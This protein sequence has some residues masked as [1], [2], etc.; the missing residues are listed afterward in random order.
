MKGKDFLS[1][2]SALI[3]VAGITL[4]TIFT[5]PLSASTIHFGV[6]CEEDF[7]NN[8]APEI[9]VYSACDDYIGVIQ[10]YYPAYNV[11]FYFNL[12]GA[13]PAF[14]YGQGAETCNSCGGVDSVDFFTMMTHGGVNG[15]VAG[16][17]MWDQNIFAYTNSMRLGDSGKQVK[18]LATFSCDTFKNDDGYFW[19]RW[20]KAFSGGLKVGVGA[21]DLL[22]TDDDDS[23][24]QDFA[25][26]IVG[27]VPIGYSWLYAVY[28]DNNDNHPTVA[29]TGAN[30]NDCWSRQGVKLS[31]LM[32][33]KVLRDGQIGYYCWTNWN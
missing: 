11:D 21:H 26:G 4:L 22:Y 10:S 14:V 16:Y 31:G 2:R 29:N 23:A 20:Q 1:F 32:G 12:Q 33:E 7:Q 30:A 9:D 13:E 6:R 3:L 24:M 17:A 28:N 19:T 25:S 5:S 15:P 27:G 18:A 8:W